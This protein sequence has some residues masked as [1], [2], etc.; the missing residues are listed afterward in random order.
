[1]EVA[2]LRVIVPR[3]ASGWLGR[4]RTKPFAQNFVRRQRV[5]KQLRNDKH[6]LEHRERGR[7]KTDK[8]FVHALARADAGVDFQLFHALA[9]KEFPTVS[10]RNLMPCI[11]YISVPQVYSVK[12]INAGDVHPGVIRPGTRLPVHEEG[13]RAIYNQVKDDA[14][15]TIVQSVVA[16]GA[17]M[18]ILA[19]PMS[20][21]GFWEMT[22]DWIEEESNE[23]NGEETD[24][25][26]LE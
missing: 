19:T 12:E 23:S 8:R 4:Q 14:A 11:D 20:I 6:P 2:R 16:N 13:F 25:D 24:Y 26:D 22:S 3:S 21:N 1:V 9:D 17:S 15:M 18:E 10:R 7:P 5:R